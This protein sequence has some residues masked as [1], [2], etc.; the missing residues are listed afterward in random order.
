MHID[1]LN[2]KI[3]DLDSLANVI[4]KLK[5]EGKKIALCHGC[6]DLLHLGHL[7]HFKEAKS[8]GDILVVTLTEDRYINK[9]PDRP[10]FS[11]EQRAEYLASLECIDFVSINRWETAVET[12]EY[13]KPDI[14][15]KGKEYK[16]AK[17]DITENILR[18]VQAVQSIGGEIY[19]TDDITFSSSNLI[20]RSIGCIS[21][22]AKDFLSQLKK[23]Y[24]F[25][26][27]RS[28][29][30]RLKSLNVLVIG[31]I[32]LDEYHYTRP[33]GMPNKAANI[34]LK[35][36]KSELHPGGIL[37]IA[38]HIAPFVNNVELFT[39]LGADGYKQFISSSM[40]KNI[41]LHLY[42]RKDAPT[43]RKTRFINGWKKTRLFEVAFIEES[44]IEK[45]LEMQILRDAA[46]KINRAD[47]VVLADFGHYFISRDIIHFLENNSKFLTIN[48]QTNS[49][50]YGFNTI[51]KVN[52][53]DYISIDERELRMRFQNNI[54]SCQELM[55]KLFQSTKVDKLAITS[56]DKGSRIA[57]RKNESTTVPT[58]TNNA[59]DTVGAGDAYLAL[60][61][62]IASQSD[63]LELIGF[64]GTVAGGIATKYLGNESSL[65]KQSVCN[66]INTLL[67]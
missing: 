1:V 20:N 28:L 30:D 9:G 29:F 50:N 11:Q 41:N 35:Y 4:Q 22:E 15:A 60:S 67:K 23:K 56:G 61:S 65:D 57:N 42:E 16:K 31:D 21:Q 45:D 46:E 39:V 59:V 7:R 2:E 52:K 10:F 64:L 8:Q 26:S 14:Y 48:V 58:F 25:S 36:L 49:L 54:H 40:K 13:L 47:L 5:D 3:L 63:D 43:V 37:A 51:S 19:Y 27:I 38:N 33:V 17:N 32:I 66:Y 24:N 44:M 55:A 62:L 6:F 53:A 18:E 12:I 34:S